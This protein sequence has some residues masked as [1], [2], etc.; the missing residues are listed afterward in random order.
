MLERQKKMCKF[1]SKKLQGTMGE[2]QKGTEE[3]SFGLP[4]GW[5]RGVPRDTAEGGKVR[6]KLLDDILAWCERLWKRDSSVK[7][8]SCEEPVTLATDSEGETFLEASKL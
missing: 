3:P 1:S 4:K 8:R 5:Q 6:A 2:S 7:K